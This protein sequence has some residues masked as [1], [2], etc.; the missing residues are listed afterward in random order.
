MPLTVTPSED[1]VVTALRA[2][3]LDLVPVGLEVVQAQ[4][5]RVPEPKGPD[6]ILMTPIRRMRLAT[7]VTEHDTFD[8]ISAAT[9]A[10]QFDYQIDIHGPDGGNLCQIITTMTRGE[11]ATEWFEK[12]HPGVSPLYANDPKQ[13]PFSSNGESQYEER[14][15][16]EI[17]L[18]A[19][20]VVAFPQQSATELAI[21]I[22]SV[23][24]EFPAQ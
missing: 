21:G 15:I 11:Y 17:S 6:F 18:Q 23:E 8:Q 1:D 3:L 24:A 7:N 19:N 14:W 5:N 12:N 9:Q 4:D 13:M 16:V 20:P 10:T 2:Y 22:K